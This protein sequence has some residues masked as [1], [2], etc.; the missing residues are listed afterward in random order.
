[1]DADAWPHWQKLGLFAR[2]RTWVGSMNPFSRTSR[3]SGPEATAFG[4]VASRTAL[5]WPQPDR[6]RHAPKGPFVAAR[7]AIGGVQTLP[8]NQKRAGWHDS[9]VPATVAEASG[10]RPTTPTPPPVAVSNV[11]AANRPVH[12]RAPRLRA[13]LVG[14]LC[15]VATLVAARSASRGDSIPHTEPLAAA[16]MPEVPLAS[17]SATDPASTKDAAQAEDNADSQLRRDGYSPIKGGVLYVPSTFSSRDGAYD[18]LIHFHGD[19]KI[20]LESAEVAKVNA[21]VAMINLG[22]GSAVYENAY[23][24][25]GTYEALL[26]QVQ[27]VIA[28]RHLRYAHLR[29]VALSSWSAGYGATS[30][31]LQVRKAKDPLDAILVLDGLHC[32]RLPERPDVLNPRQLAPFVQVARAAATGDILFSI[33]HSEIDPI[34]YVSS[35]DTATYLVDAVRELGVQE[36]TQLTPP[37]HLKLKAAAKAVEPNLEQ[38]MEPIRDL[39]VGG[40][41]VRGF[42][43]ITKEHHSAHLIQMGATVLPELAERWNRPL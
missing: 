10:S 18:L 8:R 16:T 36:E 12:H 20:V 30:T 32:G 42:R 34:A 9:P 25:P 26:A 7:S 31:I 37:E 28:D 11:A 40:L 41:H 4:R 17:L 19:V 35:K 22:I 13:A 27:Q 14:A 2:K 5:L 39:R 15:L 29:R 6:T 1:M 33:T 3:R 38:R 24:V 23:A 21:L 43:G